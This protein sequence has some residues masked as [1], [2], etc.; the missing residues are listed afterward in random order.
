[1]RWLT[2]NALFILGT[3]I[4]VGF[5]SCTEKKTNDPI[6]SYKLWAGDVPPKNANIIHGNYWQSAHWPKEYILYHCC[7]TKVGL[8]LPT[9]LCG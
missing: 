8:K 5:D 7:P 9:S 3:V 4:V 2:F 6:E 1:M